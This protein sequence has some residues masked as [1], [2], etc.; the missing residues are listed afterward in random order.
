MISKIAPDF[1]DGFAK[2]AQDGVCELLLRWVELVVGDMCVHDGLEAL[3]GVPVSAIDGQLDQM[4]AAILARQPSL[5]GITPMIGRFVPNHVNNRFGRVICLDYCQELH[6]TVAIHSDRLDERWMAGQN[7]WM[8]AIWAAVTAHRECVLQ[9][10]MLLACGGKSDFEMLEATLL[11]RETGQCL[12][13]TLYS[14]ATIELEPNNPTEPNAFCE[15]DQKIQHLEADIDI[16]IREIEI[17]LGL[18]VTQVR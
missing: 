3:N 18:T 9:D 8:A 11:V 2:V 14:D 17:M 7:G 12:R 5:E 10:L 6:R 13:L 1:R 15:L 16:A 4:D